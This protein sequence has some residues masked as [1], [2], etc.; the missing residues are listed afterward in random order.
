M[1]PFSA[2][3]FP[4]LTRRFREPR[5]PKLSYRHYPIPTYF[6]CR[7]ASA[8]WII[9]TRVRA[10]NQLAFMACGYAKFTCMRGMRPA[11]S[12]EF[13]LPIAYIAAKMNDQTRLAITCLQF[14]DP[15]SDNRR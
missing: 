4:L 7:L 1:K 15:G 2:I 9:G 13:Q 3:Y 11:T 5:G 14:H 12:A 6:T 8:N 10:F